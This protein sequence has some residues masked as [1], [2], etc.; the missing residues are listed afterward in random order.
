[1]AR[2]CP[3]CKK[4]IPAKAAPDTLPFCSSRC[5]MVDL[6]NWLQGTYRVPAQTDAQFS[7]RA[8]EIHIAPE[9]EEAED[10]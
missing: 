7:E 9:L 1:M 10:D 5:K 2:T 6:G 4:T 3:I 8:S